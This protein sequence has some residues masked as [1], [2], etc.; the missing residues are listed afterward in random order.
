METSF[1]AQA[2]EVVFGFPALSRLDN[3]STIPTPQ[4]P[5]AKNAIR[6]NN[7]TD[8]VTTCKDLETDAAPDIPEKPTAIQTALERTGDPRLLAAKRPALSMTVT[9]IVKGRRTCTIWRWPAAV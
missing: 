9:R 8:S 6:A 4:S 1:L 7:A 5:S 3:G 2:D